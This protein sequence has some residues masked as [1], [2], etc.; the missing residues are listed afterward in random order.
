MSLTSESQKNHTHAAPSCSPPPR[1]PGARRRGWPRWSLLRPTRRRAHRR[2]WLHRSPLLL[3]C[4][5]TH[6][7]SLHAPDPPPHS[8]EG[9]SCVPADLRRARR[10][11]WPPPTYF[12][13]PPPRPHRR[14]WPRAPGPPLHLPEGMA[15]ALT[16]LRRRIHHPAVHRKGR[17]KRETEKNRKK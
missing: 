14:G 11:G 1:Y 15:Y 8:L 10:R 2:G 17:Y 7:R 9:M 3:G 5:C 6:H 16:S 12:P 13:P 4:R